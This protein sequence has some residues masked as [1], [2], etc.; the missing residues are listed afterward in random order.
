MLSY[1][2]SHKFEIEVR[3]IT[4]CDNC[5]TKN[6]IRNNSFEFVQFRIMKKIINKYN[7]TKSEIFYQ[8]KLHKQTSKDISLSSIE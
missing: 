8:N 1:D 5:L 3:I 2:N 6:Y 4:L 7:V